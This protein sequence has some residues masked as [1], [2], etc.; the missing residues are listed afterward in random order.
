MLGVLLSLS[1]LVLGDAPTTAEGICKDLG[2]TIQEAAYLGL[3]GV[4]R[5]VAE[6][7]KSR[8]SGGS[9]WWSA[10]QNEYYEEEL[11]VLQVLCENAKFMQDPVRKICY[12]AGIDKTELIITN[13]WSRVSEFI[14]EGERLFTGRHYAAEK[15]SLEVRR[16]NFWHTNYQQFLSKLIGDYRKIKE[17]EAQAKIQEEKKRQEE[18]A[19]LQATEV[20]QSVQLQATLADI[21]KQLKEQSEKMD[22]LVAG[23]A[24]FIRFLVLMDSAVTSERDIRARVEAAKQLLE[25]DLIDEQQKVLLLN[26]KIKELKEK[27]ET[28]A[29]ENAELRAQMQA[30]LEAIQVQLKERMLSMM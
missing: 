9:Q 3:F 5:E 12:D 15:R 27:A 24:Q 8:S 14:E 25:S 18:K 20:K 29:V 19:R 7:G 17:R 10:W 16:R 22:K 6:S 4:I 13:L 2:I 26:N 11:P 28:V 21:Q 23:N 1:C 30:E